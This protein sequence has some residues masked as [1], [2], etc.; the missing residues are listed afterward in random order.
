M[1]LN[2]VRIALVPALQYTSLG[3]LTNVGVDRISNLES[4]V[5]GKACFETFLES[6]MV[7]IAT[8]EHETAFTHFVFF[9]KTNVFLEITAEEHVN[10]LEHVLCVH[11]LHREDALVSEQVLTLFSHEFT[12]PSLQFVDVEFAHKFGTR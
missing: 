8:D 6:L 2:S 5:F 4:K 3:E 12:N 1:N 10:A 11:A 7:E 9:P